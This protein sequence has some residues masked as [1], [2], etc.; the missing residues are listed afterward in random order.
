MGQLTGIRGSNR[1]KNCLNTETVHAR[2]VAYAHGPLNQSDPDGCDIGDICGAQCFLVLS[3][4]IVF[5][6]VLVTVLAAFSF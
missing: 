6:F 5:V 3:V 2:A 4:I 1:C